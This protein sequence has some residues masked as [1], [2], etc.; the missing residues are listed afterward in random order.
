M[1][2]FSIKKVMEKYTFLNMIRKIDIC[3]QLNIKITTRNQK[4]GDKLVEIPET[5]GNLKTKTFRFSHHNVNDKEKE[6]QIH[7]KAPRQR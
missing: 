7:S 3:D 1:T 6:L 2:T 5:G 4:Y